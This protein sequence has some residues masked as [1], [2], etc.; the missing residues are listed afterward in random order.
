[1]SERSIW[2]KDAIL[3][4]VQGLTEFLPISSSGHLIASRE[5]LGVGADLAYDV[6]LHVATLLAVVIYFRNDLM[7]L[8][9]HRRRVHVALLVVLATVPGVLL[10]VALASWRQEID[11]WWVVGGWLFSATYLLLSKGRSGSVSYRELSLARGLLVGTA[12]ALAIFPGVSRS[13]SSITAGLWLGLTRDDA[14]RFSF[15]IAIPI[16]IGAGLKKGLE[17]DVSKIAAMGGWPPA[18]LG[19]TVAF[20]VGLAA[21][22]ILLRLVTRNRLHTFGWYNLA[23]ALL[24]AAYL[25]AR[26]A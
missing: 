26:P 2:Y 18:L 10:G 1:M 6:A 11:P 15:L 19:M 22:H 12:Q 7:A 16:M 24:F 13:G 23:A 20:V 25:L 5:I 14:C 17:L 8:L 4:L 21:I 9:R 3:G